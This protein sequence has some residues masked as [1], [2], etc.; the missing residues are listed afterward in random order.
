[1]IAFY[2]RQAPELARRYKGL[3]ELH[4]RE[5]F[6][7]FMKLLRGKDI[8]DL[9]CC[10][11][12]NA[13]CFRDHGSNVT[14]TAIA[15]KMVELARAKGID[16]CVMNL[17]EMT[18]SDNSFDGIWAVTSLPH[19][20][21]E[22][23]PPVVQALRRILKRDGVLHACVKEVTGEGFIADKGHPE[24]TRYFAFYQED[25]FLRLFAPRSERA[26]LRDGRTRV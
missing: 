6:L 2:D 5:E 23:M 10:G 3:F 24:L 7:H 11:R 8:L 15:P 4:C 21:M 1:M 20:P 16:A 14:S 18:F 12:D 22:R 25:E 26:P 19:P 9:D 17:E 13:A